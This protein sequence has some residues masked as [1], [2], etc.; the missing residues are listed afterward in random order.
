MLIRLEI[1]R[2]GFTALGPAS[3]TN[4]L[5]PATINAAR[6]N[7][8]SK[9][10]DHPRVECTHTSGM[11]VAFEN[12]LMS[13]K[14]FSTACSSRSSSCTLGKPRSSR[15]LCRASNSNRF[16][17]CASKASAGVAPAAS[18][19]R[20]PSSRHSITWRPGPLPH[21]IRPRRSR[22]RAT[23]FQPDSV[24]TRRVILTR[25]WCPPLARRTR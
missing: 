14:N 20:L 10:K 22:S 15:L 25:A 5:L 9:F 23:L 17:F 12:A 2:G 19:K 24:F 7:G 3:V 1:V 21:L 4:R 8:R 6:Q 16:R 11:A 18:L 13:F